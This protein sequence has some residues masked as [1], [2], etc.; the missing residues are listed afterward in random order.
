VNLLETAAELKRGDTHL[1][2]TLANAQA[3]LADTF[4]RRG[5][6]TDSLR[7]RRR[8]HAVM[9]ALRRRESRSAEADFRYAAADRGLA[10]SLWKT[11]DRRGAAR[12]FV[13]AY[14]KAA[15]LARSDP[16]NAGWRLLK[17]KLADD[18]RRGEIAFPPGL[19]E[20]KAKDPSD[21]EKPEG[22]TK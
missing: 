13:E 4:Y 7:E 18:L 22:C 12:Y 17:D 21:R 14:E 10:C 3:W 15:P 2:L 8:Q 16:R 9:T 5:L 20:A 11:G 19:A 6:W 1:Q